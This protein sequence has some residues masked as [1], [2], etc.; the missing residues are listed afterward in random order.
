MLPNNHPDIEER[1]RQLG[2]AVKLVYAS[3]YSVEARSYLRFS[4]HLPDEEKMAVIVQH[5]VGRLRGEGGRRYYPS[6]SGVVQSYNYYPVPPIA[7]DDGVAYVAL[8]LGKTIM[9]G[10]RSLRFSPKHPHHLHQF[11]TVDDYLAN[12]QREFLALDTLSASEEL[13]Y[14]HEPS[15][16]WLGLETAEADHTLSPVG[17]TYS[18][19]NECVYDGTSRPGVRLVTFAP[20]LKDDVFPLP[21]ILNH[22][23]RM[24]MESMGS[25]VEIEFAANLDRGEDGLR[26]FSILQ[27]RPMISRW[28]TQKVRIDG[29]PGQRVL[30]ES[31][32]ALGNGTV[33]NVTDVVYVKPQS[34]DPARTV[35][36]AGEIGR[37]NEVLK[38]EGRQCLL[39]GPGR[40]GSADPWLGIPV[41]WNQISESRVIVET[42]LQDFAIDPSYGTH[43][44]HNVTSLGLGYFTV[45]GQ[46]G[47]G[48]LRWDWFDGQPALAETDLLRHVRLAKPLDIRID[49][50]TGRGVILTPL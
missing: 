20:I 31:P 27:M 1:V 46:H 49:G 14:E 12:S 40:W 47:G 39:M 37:I 43:F 45:H 32:R 18:A 3:T 25:H 8:G 13:G 2:R 34:F 28:S 29:E 15:M 5:L 23:T 11:S 38:R 35:E 17:S 26:E 24:G 30:C 9:D 6:F 41:R 36:I 4:T 10:Y 21:D 42:T 7:A 16:T 19:E 22:I 44:F 50:S 33:Q 48:A